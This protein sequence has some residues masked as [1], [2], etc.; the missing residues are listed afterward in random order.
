LACFFVAAKLFH[1]VRDLFF[2]F[3]VAFTG[4]GTSDHALETSAH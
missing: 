1:R 2:R 4:V 3:R